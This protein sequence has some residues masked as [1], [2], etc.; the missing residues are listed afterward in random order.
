MIIN[1]WKIY[2]SAFNLWK[3]PGKRRLLRLRRENPGLAAFSWRMS[4]SFRN[5]WRNRFGDR[6]RELGKRNGMLE[7]RTGAGQGAKSGCSR[8]KIGMPEE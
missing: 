3:T 6:Q 7:G 8:R 4:G 2:P 1:L 5:R